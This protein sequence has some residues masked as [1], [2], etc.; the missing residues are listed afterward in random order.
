MA[1]GT[2]V[3]INRIQKSVAVGIKSAW[4]QESVFRGS[5]NQESMPVGIVS[6]AVGTAVPVSRIQKYVA[7][8]IKSAWV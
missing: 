1:V 4:V 8:G 7:V 6:L 5:R 2:A 3:P